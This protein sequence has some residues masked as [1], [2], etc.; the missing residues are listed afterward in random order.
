[1]PTMYVL[2]TLLGAAKTESDQDLAK[3]SASNQLTF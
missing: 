1:M 2:G 3:A